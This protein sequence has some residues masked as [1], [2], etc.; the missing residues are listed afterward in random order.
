[1]LGGGEVSLPSAGSSLRCTMGA[2]RHDSLAEE[3]Q[4]RSRVAW[5]GS[6]A[7]QMMF[8]LGLEHALV[9]MDQEAGQHVTRNGLQDDMPCAAS[10]ARLN[11]CWTRLEQTLVDAGH[12]LR[13]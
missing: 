7:M 10:A 13:R 1:M 12:Q 8:V 4:A 2:M 11:Q 3:Q 9:R 6:I 5:Q